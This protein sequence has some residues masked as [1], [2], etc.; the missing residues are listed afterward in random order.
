MVQLHP[1]HLVARLQHGEVG[2]HVGLRAAV[3]LDVDVLGPEQLPGALH[4]QPFN[5]VYVFAAAV[6]APAGVAL[7]ILVVHHAGLGLE[8]RLAGVVFGRDQYN[9]LALAPVFQ[10]QGP[11]NLR[12]LLG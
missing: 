11:G 8:H 1:H 6:V 4:C 2:A 9:A 3:G 7:G 12:V 5:R 10:L